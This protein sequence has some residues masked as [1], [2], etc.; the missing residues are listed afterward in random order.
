MKMII[1]FSF[2]SSIFPL[3]PLFHFSTWRQSIYVVVGNIQMQNTEI[4]K[5][6]VFCICFILEG[7]WFFPS[8]EN[9]IW[10]PHFVQCHMHVE[11][12]SINEDISFIWCCSM[13]N[14]KF[15]IF[16]QFNQIVFFHF[17]LFVWYVFNTTFFMETIL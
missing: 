14:K 5:S 12:Y 3:N 15:I 11:R 17:C 16:F 6:S 7:T 1:F 4:L 10:W 2:I 9:L 8:L 13:N